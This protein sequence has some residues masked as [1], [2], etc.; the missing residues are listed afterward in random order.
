MAYFAITPYD[1]S[2]LRSTLTDYMAEAV[3]D[4]RWLALV[5]TAFD[6]EGKLLKMAGCEGLPVYHQGKL[7]ILASVSPTL[8]ELSETAP[9][10]LDRQL[11]RLL[12]HCCG[13]PMLSFIRS[14]LPVEV[15][16]ER[17]QKLL[18]VETE[19]SQSYLM[20][21]ADTR[22][23][24]ALAEQKDIW[25][26]LATDITTWWTVGRNG[27]LT[28]LD[29]PQTPEHDDSPLRIS[30]DSLSALLEAGEVDAMAE[31]MYEY[32]PDLLAT[33]DG[34]ANYRLLAQATAL[35]DKHGI[36]GASEQYAL[37]V[38]VLLTEGRLLANP[39]FEDWL[40]EKTWQAQGIEEAL[41]E[42]MEDKDIS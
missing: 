33:R 29:M 22:V 12:H 36:Q 40:A 27:S 17:W 26:R 34:A 2:A 19:D 10:L 35:Y 7:Q 31:Y 6:H 24:P 18:E 41:A 32:F 25:N 38:A 3:G 28:A 39:A 4:D 8:F 9:D 11:S 42:F 20:R 30:N 1:P 15:L 13:R 16:C 14:P 37:G 5:D 23:L 21:F